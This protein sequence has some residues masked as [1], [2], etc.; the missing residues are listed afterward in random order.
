MIQNSFDLTNMDNN[1]RPQDDFNLYVN[2]NWMKNNPIPKKYTKWGSFEILYEETNKKIKNLVENE[3]TDSEFRNISIMFNSGINQDRINKEDYK[4]IKVYLDLVDKISS[5]KDL[6]IIMAKLY[7]SGISVPFYFGPSEDAKNSELVVPHIGTSGLG[8]PDR[9]YY[10]LND[11]HQERQDYLEYIM[12]L[13]ILIGNCAEDAKKQA[14]IIM[15]IETQLAGVTY[16][17]V[18]KRDP[19][20]NYNKFTMCELEKLADGFDWALYFNNLVDKEISYLIID[21]PNYFR[22]FT[23]MFLNINISSWIIYLKYKIISRSA[24]YLSENFENTKFE[25]YGKKLS[26]QEELKPRW[27]RVLET[28]SSHIGELLGKLY[29]TKYFPESSKKKML[30][31]VYRLLDVL[32]ER[33]INLE[34]MSD[35]TKQKA[36]LKHQAFKIKIGYPDKWHCYHKLQL[37]K[38]YSYIDNIILSNVFEFDRDMEKLYKPTDLDEWEMDAHNINAYFHP[39]KNEIV[40]PAGI[41]QYPFFDPNIDDAINYGGIGT[42]IAHEM[43]HSFDDQGRKFDNY[44]NLNNWWSDDDLCKFNS[45]A[46]YFKNEYSTYKVN[47]KNVNG[48]LTLGENLADH[49]GVKIS[50]NALLKL[51]DDKGRPNNIDGFTPEQRFFLSWAQVWRYNIRDKE[52]DK[53]LIIDPHSPNEWRINGTLAN[54]PEFHKIFNVTETDKLWRLNP[55]QIW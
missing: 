20:K 43:T 9:D 21:N 49:G 22:T 12:K 8:L 32:K 13:F 53:R 1:V 39:L 51:L 37:D 25:F 45:K 5:R 24:S 14:N 55:V 3:Y 35:E 17:K 6:L 52:A 33:I 31:L 7:R 26:G 11:K 27:E 47:G 40:F 15:N 54:I 18:E 4:P 28:I 46:K 29:I 44:G 23:D 2:G 50:Y 48:E 38:K 34:W 42:V 41:L 10:L 36:L 16:T 19:D 30:D